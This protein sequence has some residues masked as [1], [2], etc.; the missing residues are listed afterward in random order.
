MLGVEQVVVH[1]FSC[2]DGP[3]GI[4]YRHKC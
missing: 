2:N 4:W 1:L 3:F